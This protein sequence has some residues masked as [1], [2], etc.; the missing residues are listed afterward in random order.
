MGK[1]FGSENAEEITP[2]D[3]L[4]IKIGTFLR[5]YLG[6]SYFIDADPKRG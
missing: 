3:F 1:F 5:D 6:Q 2:F 4:R